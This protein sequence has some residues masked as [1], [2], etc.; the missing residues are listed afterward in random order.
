MILVTGA[1]GQLGSD[2]CDVLR[3]Q[4]KAFLGVDVDTLDITDKPAVA[5]FFEAHPD[6]DSVI[7][8]A[9]YTA[10]DKA[11]DDA[12]RCRAV[13]AGGTANLA[14]NAKNCKFLYVS[15][16]YVFGADGAEPLETD[17]P[18]APK[19][20]YGKTKLEG[21][22]AVM[23]NCSRFFIVRT[24][25]VFGEKNTNFIATI[26]RL[27]ETHD[28]LRVVNDQI[29]APT[30][31]RD[32][33]KLLVQMLETERFGVYHAANTGAC[34]WAELA[35]TV[36]SLCGKATAVLNVSTE[37][38]GA[39]AK[40]PKNSRFSFRSLDEAGFARLRPWEDAVKDYLANLGELR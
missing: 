31:S 15:T 16:D 34:S 9:A 36:L 39:K 7:H 22:E 18:K 35:E 5:A 23:N 27:S 12:E 4:N 37:E 30:Y 33:A 19:C 25:G 26:L 8:C 13:N 10:V 6:I 3:A 29:G 24:S 28:T 21:E 32:L 20:V 2:V 40:R 1:K 11:E 38:Y 17:A 14:E